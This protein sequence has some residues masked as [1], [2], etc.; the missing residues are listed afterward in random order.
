MKVKAKMTKLKTIALGVMMISMA[1]ACGTG[2]GSNPV[3][4]GVQGPD[5]TYTNGNFMMSMVLTNL[6]LSGGGTIPIPNMPASSFEI[7]PDLQSA[8]TLVAVSLSAADIAALTGAN[9]LNPTELPGNR[10]LP[11]I[12]NGS[13]PAIAVQV[14][15]WD[16]MV[17]YVGP[18]IFGVFVPVNMGLPAGYELT[19]SLY[20]TAGV[21]VGN[22]S[23]VGLDSTGKNSGVLV[24]IPIKGAVANIINNARKN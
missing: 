8:G 3:I 1:T 6:T 11:G 20:S 12:T 14:P 15:A 21:A 4:A 2:K 24:L 5:I 10:P 16:S 23:V 19:A 9:L 22:I 17:F 18:T 7:T 13:L